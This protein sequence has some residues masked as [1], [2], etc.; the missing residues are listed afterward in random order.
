MPYYVQVYK[1][2]DLNGPPISGQ[3]GTAIVV[4]NA[5]LVD[6]YGWTG[7]SITG[8]T[9]SSQTAT[10]TV[11]AANGLKLKTGMILTVAG[12]NESEYNGTFTITVASTTTF[13]YTV[14]GTPATPAT[15]TITCDNFLRI[16]SIT[17]GGVG[18]LTATVTTLNNNLTLV[19]GNWLTISGC[20]S[21]GAA[22]YNGTFQITVTGPTTFT[23][24]MTADPTASAS[25]SPV[26]T[27]AGLQWTR[28]FSAGTN[29][30]TYK[31]AATLGALGEAYTPYPLQVVD[32]GVVTAYQCEVYSAEAMS[33]DQTVLSAMFPTLAQRAA[34][35]LLKKTVAANSTQ[36][37]WTLW[38]DE[39]TFTLGT[40][41]GD[42]AVTLHDGC[43]S[44]GYFIPFRSGDQYN[45][46]I[47][48]N[49][50]NAT[51]KY[52]GAF[53][54]NW[55]ASSP[56]TPTS[57]FYIP[58]AYYQYGTS[59]IGWLTVPYATTGA[60]AVIGSTATQWL[61]FPSPVDNACYVTPVFIS[62]AAGNLRGR[63]PGFYCLL[64]PAAS[65]THFDT[66]TNISGLS[67]VTL[68]A[69]SVV[70][71]SVTGTALVDMFGPW[72]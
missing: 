17:R 59:T 55:L 64:H 5:C 46:F 38:G 39:K 41:T 54:V 45:T 22:Q 19:T 61:T 51:N 31:S 34:N 63:M 52:S 37:E 44:F 4:L 25:G 67:G 50:G 66:V 11:S 57:S 8:I 27:K 12:A 20:T 33:A 21:T 26:Y 9:R 69:V 47:A 29:A 71:I 7:M 13:T 15:G 49:S 24:Q 10:A 14:T 58:R 40:V 36:R 32:N 65:F 3:T 28:P 70:T 30:Q 48:F 62:D 56:T 60:I 43:L 16:S 1:S 23:Y 2:T 72:T 53:G 42:F 35:G 68:M 18:N 6:G